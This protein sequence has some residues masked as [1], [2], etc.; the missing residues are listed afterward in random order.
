[1]V[2]EWSCLGRRVVAVPRRALRTVKFQCGLV[3]N[4][5]NQARLP[6][7]MAPNV[8]S[9]ALVNALAGSSQTPPTQLFKKGECVG[10]GAFGSVHRG[11]H[12]ATNAVVALKIINLDIADDDVEAI[13]KE[14]ALLSQ[15]R[16]GEA[17]NVT[18]YYGSWLDGARVWIVMDFASGGSVRTLVSLEGGLARAP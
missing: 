6:H 17:S 9:T 10:K 3:S 8:S 1:M 11:I 14:V 4:F 16:G 18:Q 12:I 2:V 15:L 7:A 5:R 13:Q